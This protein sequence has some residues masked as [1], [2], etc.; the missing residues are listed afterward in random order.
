MKYEYNGNLLEDDRI[1]LVANEIINKYPYININQAREI[2]M[3]EGKISTDKN[4]E[5]EF[6]R[7]Y[8]IMLVMSNKKEFLTPIYEDLIELIANNK[9]DEKIDYYYNIALEIGHFLQNEREFP[10]LDEF[11]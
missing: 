1:N 11:N 10:Y 5:I 4:I 9:N 7:L 3:L 6:I 2:A 8:N